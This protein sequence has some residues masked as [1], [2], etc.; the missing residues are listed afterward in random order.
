MLPTHRV[1]NRSDVE[2]AVGLLVDTMRLARSLA[3]ALAM[4]L[5]VTLASVVLSYPECPKV[6]AYVV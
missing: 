5:A 2:L 1:E 3:V 6:V 4:F